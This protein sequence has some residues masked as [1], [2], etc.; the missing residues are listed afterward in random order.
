MSAQ[1][2]TRERLARIGVICA[3]IIASAGLALDVVRRDAGRPGL[4]EWPAAFSLIGIV[5]PAVAVLLAFA[6][7]RIDRGGASRR[8]DP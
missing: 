3:L 1:K 8:K 7:S 2:L 6:W 5:A 4:A